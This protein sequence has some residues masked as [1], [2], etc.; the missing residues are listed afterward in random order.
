MERPTFSPSWSRVNRL[1]PSLRPQVQVR[2]RVLRGQPWYVLHDPLGN[3]FSRLNPVAYHF[4]GLLDG[5]AREMVELRYLFDHAVLLDGIK[6]TRLLPGFAPTPL[7]AAI[8]TTL[9]SY[10]A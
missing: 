9:Q 7:E 1:T 10:R 3:Q 8:D 2:R 4:V 5:P 6:L